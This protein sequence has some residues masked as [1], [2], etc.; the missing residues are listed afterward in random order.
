MWATRFIATFIFALYPGI[1]SAQT[2]DFAGGARSMGMGGASVSISDAWA[3]FN[4]IGALAG[5][6]ENAFG[7]SYLTLYGIE[8]FNAVSACLNLPASDFNYGFGV[9]YFGDDLY[10]EGRLTAGASHKI[11]FVSLGV[12]ASYLRYNVREFASHGSFIVEAGGKAELFPGF[13]VAACVFNVN[14]AKAPGE[15]VAPVLMRAG[16]SF[17][18]G[19]N[20]TIN[21]D[22][23]KHTATPAAVK[24]GIEYVPAS[25]VSFRTGIATNPSRAHFGLG[26]QSRFIGVDYGFSSHPSL[27]LSSQVS[28]NIK[29]RKKS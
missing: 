17:R 13:H 20:L 26:L 11:K 28:V 3:V 4:N 23:E 7:V 24:P 12:A 21:I 5:T 16:V 15:R 2:I 1:I 14:K 9:H 18:P 27:G 19:E 6:D 10:N 25:W 29:L 8:G 22:F